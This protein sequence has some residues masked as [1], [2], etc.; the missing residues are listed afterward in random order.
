MSSLF[1]LIIKGLTFGWNSWSKN[2]HT[3]IQSWK[4][5][6]P[7]FPNIKKY[8][9]SI[10]DGILKRRL[11]FEVDMYTATGWVSAGTGI[12]CLIL[13]MP[14]IFRN[15]FTLSFLSSSLFPSSSKVMRDPP[16]MDPG[17]RV[18]NL[19]YHID[20]VDWLLQ[21]ICWDIVGQVGN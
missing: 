12:L 6:V 10:I 5:W 3:W 17:W 18:C 2:C 14:G 7:S 11:S 20:G 19:R 16:P 4:Y 1:I 9:S 13:Y 8:W 15:E 21:G